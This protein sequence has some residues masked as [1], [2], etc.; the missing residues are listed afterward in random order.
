MGMNI[1]E[2]E[3]KMARA[4]LKQYVLKRQE[5]WTNTYDEQV[6]GSKYLNGLQF[7]I[8]QVPG[9]AAMAEAATLLT[10]VTDVPA[11]QLGTEQYM[12]FVDKTCNWVMEIYKERASMDILEDLTHE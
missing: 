8:N 5:F 2:A 4:L 3:L 1:S 12:R 11:H 10:R 9:L 7:A 6:L